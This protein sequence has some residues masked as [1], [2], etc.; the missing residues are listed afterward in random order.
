[1]LKIKHLFFVILLAVSCGKEKV[2]HLPAIADSDISEINDV[3]PA[4]LFYNETLP[5]SVEL[6]RKNLIS[7]TNWLINID[8][9][10]RLK[11]VVPHI[12]FLQDKKQNASHK[13]K[14]AKNYFTCNNLSKKTLGFIPFTDVVY[15][16]ITISDL[17]AEQTDLTNTLILSIHA[18]NDI[19]IHNIQGITTVND[20]ELIHTINRF[21]NNT[22]KTNLILCFNGMLSF[23]DYIT[24]KSLLLKLDS[25]NISR[26]NTEFISN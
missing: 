21:I 2:I 1:M 9:R 7:T 13:N 12:T 3:S 4:Y 6:N 16:N 18:L 26:V 8:K 20:S 25:K 22:Q 15:K 10:L 23:Q 11:Q 17:L 5:D 24:I 19:K 14:A